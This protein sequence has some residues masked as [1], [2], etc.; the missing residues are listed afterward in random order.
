M[1]ENV[2]GMINDVKE[3]IGVLMTKI[4]ANEARLSELENVIFNDL[5]NPI[6]KSY[7]EAEY[8]DNLNTF[9]ET[10]KDKFEPLDPQIKA[11]EGEDFDFAKNTFDEYNNSDKEMSESDYVDAVVEKVSTQLETIKEKL[12]A[13]GIDA[14]T[15]EAKVTDEGVEIEAKNEEG[16]VVATETEIEQVVEGEAPIE[17]EIVEEVEPTSDENDLADFEDELNAE[18]DKFKK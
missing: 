17:T 14:E 13:N 1:D 15:V 10:Y 5:I 9:K 18:M 12:N 6:K 4:D 7:E 2:I 16:E 8:N 3:L 11:V